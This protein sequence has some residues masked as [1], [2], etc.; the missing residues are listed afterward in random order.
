VVVTG[1]QTCAGMWCGSGRYGY[2]S[3]A[4][5]PFETRTCA[6]GTAGFFFVYLHVASVI[7]TGFGTQMSA[8]NPLFTYLLCLGTNILMGSNAPK[9]GELVEAAYYIL[10]DVY[11]CLVP[12]NEHEWRRVMCSCSFTGTKQ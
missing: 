10:V 9:K 8:A 6:V 11:H 5:Y 2:G 7:F 1:L 3:A 12:V 4:R